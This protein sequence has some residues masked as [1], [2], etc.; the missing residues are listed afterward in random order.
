MDLS[1]F[2]VVLGGRSLKSNIEIHDVRWVLGE[3]IEDTFPELR[4]QWIGKKSGLHIDSYKCIKYV[5]GYEI[6]LSKSSKDSLISPKIEDLSLW[7]VNL[8]GYN[9]KKM[10]EEHDFNLIVAKKAIEA[11]KKA[12]KD[13][14]TNLKNKHN[15]DCSGINYLEKVEDMHPIKIKNWEISLIPDPE[16]R[17]EKI[18]P[19]WYGYRRI[20]NL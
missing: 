5:D 7:F 15:D 12:K 10:Y 19:D 4:K 2:I 14:E 8:G 3:S 11:K 16:K 9:P 20:D 1:L 6:V 13:W 17:S 18:I